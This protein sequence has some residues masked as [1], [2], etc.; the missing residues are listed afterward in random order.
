MKFPYRNNGQLFHH[1]FKH[2]SRGVRSIARKSAPINVIFYYP[3]TKDGKNELEK[4][5]SNIHAD[6]VNQYLKNLN[7]PTE[8][9]LKLLN[10][11]IETASIEKED[12]LTR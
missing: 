8:Q 1:K 9:K 3:K 5:V 10:A 6:I 4:Q 11:V 12:E 7:C 2:Q